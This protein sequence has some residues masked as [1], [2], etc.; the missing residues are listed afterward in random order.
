MNKTPVMSCGQGSARSL[1]SLLFAL[2]LLQPFL[3]GISHVMLFI[4]NTLFLVV[5]FH[6]FLVLK[7]FFTNHMAVISA[8]RFHASI[9]RAWNRTSASV[10]RYQHISSS[11]LQDCMDTGSGCDNHPSAIRWLTAGIVRILRTRY[12]PGYIP[13]TSPGQLLQVL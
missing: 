3:M 7:I 13:Y 6:V 5:H 11:I 10:K 1:T 4:L 9:A 2:P 8:L 12:R